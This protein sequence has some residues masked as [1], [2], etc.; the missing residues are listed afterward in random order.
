MVSSISLVSHLL[1]SYYTRIHDY[2]IQEGRVRFV[3]QNKRRC[4]TGQ[5]K[6]GIMSFREPQVALFQSVPVFFD[7]SNDSYRLWP[8]IES[9][10]A[11]ETRFLC[12]FHSNQSSFT[13]FSE[14]DFNYEFVL[15][16]KDKL[17]MFK[18]TGK[19]VSVFELSQLLFS[20][21]I[22]HEFQSALSNTVVSPTVFLDIV[23]VRTPARKKPFLSFNHTG[24][25]TSLFSNHFDAAAA[26]GT[27][28]VLPNIRDSGRW[29]NLPLCP[30]QTERQRKLVA[31]TWT[32]AR[33]KRRGDS[34]EIHDAAARLREWI[35][36]HKLV[37]FDHFYVYDNTDHGGNEKYVSPLRA[38][39]EALGEDLVTYHHWPAKV[40]SNNRPNHAN[41]GE[42]SSQ[43]AAEA[44]CRTRY[45]SSTTWMAF[46]DTDEY[47]VPANHSSWHDVLDTKDNYDVLKMRSSRGKPRVEFMEP[48]NQC[49]MPNRRRAKIAT[50][51]CLVPKQNETFLRVYKYVLVID[52][53]PLDTDHWERNLFLILAAVTTF[54]R[55]APTDLIER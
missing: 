1:F 40:C 6:D 47:M 28:H 35:L 39:A 37:G 53:R 22:P 45:G 14:Y 26:F 48:I 27:N 23:P 51:S 46:L 15:W 24:Y 36:F 50:D 17:P 19:D 18:A 34:T 20:C 38:I 44:S 4:E 3:A 43:Y 16:R 55:H 12:R 41:P 9:A 42:R 8:D 33:Y 7:R 25:R 5:G 31:C 29:A 13:T 52:H 54:D 32:A 10:T 11:P 2:V 30:V 49:E 21:P